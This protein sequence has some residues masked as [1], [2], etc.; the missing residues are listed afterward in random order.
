MLGISLTRSASPFSPFFIVT[1][2]FNIRGS[3]EAG[4]LPLAT[5]VDRLASWK[6]MT[7]LILI[8]DE[9]ALHLQYKTQMHCFRKSIRLAELSFWQYLVQD[10]FGATQLLLQFN[11]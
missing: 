9:T 1:L 10:Y 5:K 7:K 4:K 11:P 3:H 2:V 6:S 8:S